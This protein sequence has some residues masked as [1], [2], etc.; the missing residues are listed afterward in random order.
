MT[1]FYLSCLSKG[2]TSKYSHLMRYW[3]VKFQH[4]NGG[5]RD[6]VQPI[7]SF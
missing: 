4:M 7:I 1:T 5:K 6:T 3:G 2:P